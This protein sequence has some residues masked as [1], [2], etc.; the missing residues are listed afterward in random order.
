MKKKIFSFELWC[1]CGILKLSWQDF[2][3]NGSVL[4]QVHV[5]RAELLEKII[6]RRLT[7]FGHIARKPAGE[8][9]SRIIQK[10]WRK[11]GRG[12]RRHWLKDDVKVTGCRDIRKCVQLAQ[13]KKSRKLF[14]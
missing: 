13:K 10:D 8:E 6:A 12:R 9:L 7:F 1:Y 14:S 2:V 4:E 3:S 11:T 5:T